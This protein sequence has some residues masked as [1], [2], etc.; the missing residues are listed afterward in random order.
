MRFIPVL[1]RERGSPQVPGASS[2]FPVLAFLRE[3]SGLL[4]QS[5]VDETALSRRTTE[6]VHHCHQKRRSSDVPGGPGPVV[7]QLFVLFFMDKALERE[8]VWLQC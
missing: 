6:A 1:L 2:D 4:T 7:A 5:E 3:S 8:K